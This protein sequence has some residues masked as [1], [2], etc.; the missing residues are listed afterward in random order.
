MTLGSPLLSHPGSTRSL[1]VPCTSVYSSSD[2]V[3]PHELAVIPPGPSCESVEVR[4]SHVGLG[5]NPAA[6][7]VVADRLAQ[8]EGR[9]Q[10]FRPHPVLNPLY[11]SVRSRAA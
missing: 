5:H 11:P 4:G 2:A 3:V 10:P 1:P 9:W 7:L 6:L 8:P